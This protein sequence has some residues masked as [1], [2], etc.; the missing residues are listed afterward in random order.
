MTP[1]RWQQIDRLLELALDQKSSE[2]AD[3]LEKACAGDKEL[4][5]EVEALLVAHGQAGSL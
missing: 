1:E 5:R 3:F 4:C 2:R